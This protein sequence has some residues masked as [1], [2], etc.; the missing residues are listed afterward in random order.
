MTN[1]TLAA[2]LYAARVEELRGSRAPDRDEAPPLHVRAAAQVPADMSTASVDFWAGEA[3]AANGAAASAERL[4][5]SG[6]VAHWARA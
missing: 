1:T 3:P 5:G 4:G 2:A 6:S